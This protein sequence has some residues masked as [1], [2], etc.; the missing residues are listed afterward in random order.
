MEKLQID[1]YA[2]FLVTLILVL[3]VSAGYAADA[4]DSEQN[5]GKVEEVPDTTMKLKGGAEGTLFESLKIEGEDRIHIEFERPELILNL[6][7]KSARGLDWR[8]LDAVLDQLGVSLMAPFMRNTAGLRRQCFA[9]PW[10]DQFSIDGV[11]RFRP[12]VEG[13]DR[14]R[15]MVADSKGKTVAAFE[16]KNKPP[17]E[18]V[19][20]GRSLEG[21]PV[22]PGL[23][24]SY[25]LEAYDRAG[26]KRNFIGE[27]FELPAYRIDTS[28]GRMMLFSGKEFTGAQESNYGKEALPPAVIL[29]VANF[30]NMESDLDAPVHVEVS[31]R[32]Y[33]EADRLSGDIV[34]RLKPFLLGNVLRVQPVSKVQPDAPDCG[35]VVVLLPRSQPDARISR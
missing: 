6:D 17:K 13:V 32:S 26:N 19:W 28:E 7:P 16:G 35:T 22:P 23:T 21:Q 18:I 11:A 27:G 14:W 15:L 30:I 5:T 29:D 20:D 33:E 24:Y 31:A 12:E 10:L 34:M 8:S 2:V 9:R 25:L 3:N 1:K 4:N